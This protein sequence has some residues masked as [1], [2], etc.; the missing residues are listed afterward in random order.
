MKN[1]YKTS[2]R[3]YSMENK[4][5]ITECYVITLL[6]NFKKFYNAFR[7]INN[8]KIEKK[9]ILDFLKQLLELEYYEYSQ[10]QFKI[11]PN[12][13]K[14]QFIRKCQGNEL[15]TMKIYKTYFKE[16]IGHRFI[17]FLKR[18]GALDIYK[19]NLNKQLN[20]TLLGR[21]LFAEPQFYIDSF[22]WVQT[23]QGFD[24]WEDLQ[25]EWMD[26]VKEDGEHIRVTQGFYEQ[27]KKLIDE[28]KE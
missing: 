18:N 28:Y 4:T 8:L 12:D 27:I 14:L 25:D 15:E 1:I 17:A 24:Y 20:E 10:N 6:N 3:I 16:H 5:K 22:T 2:Y 13:F 26:I 23:K 19:Y 21:I 7:K 9:L 11:F